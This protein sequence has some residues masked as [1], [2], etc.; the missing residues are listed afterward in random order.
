[1]TSIT[2]DTILNA[3]NVDR[4]ITWIAG[5]ARLTNLSGRLL[6]AH[7]AHAGLI[8]FWA[9][10]IALFELFRYDPTISMGQ[11]GL[12]LLP[13][14]A[15]LGIGVGAGGVITDPE[16]IFNVAVVHLISSAVLG[17]GGIFHSLR[18]PAVLNENDKFTGFFGYRWDDGNK[19]TTIIGIHLILLGAGAWLLVLKAMF[20]GG[21]FDPA[22]AG[23]GDLRVITSPSIRP[24][25]IFGYLVGQHG[26]GGMTAVDSLEDIVGG[27]IWV[28][29]LCILGGMWHCASQ[30]LSWA[31]KALVW[32]GEAYLSY[33]LAALAYMGAIASYFVWQNGLVYPEMFYGPLQTLRY[34]DGTVSARG[35]LCAFHV[36]FSVM[37]LLGHIWHAIQARGV[38]AGYNFRFA[39]ETGVRPVTLQNSAFEGVLA[40]PVNS[41]DYNRVFFAKLPIFRSGLSPLRRGLEV[42]MAH[43]YWLLGPFLKLGPMRDT[44]N[45]GVAGLGSAVGLVVIGSILLRIYGTAAYSSSRVEPTVTTVTLDT[46]R[47]PEDMRSKLGWHQFALGFL[48]GGAGSAFFAYIL[49]HPITL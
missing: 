26:L 31:K 34:A 14:L 5:N 47:L 44:P 18:G 25:Q 23:G 29:S 38:M 19:M 45:A 37:F 9:G 11:Q 30:P 17:A 3:T 16:T 20:F 27:H 22:I 43:G 42:G 40:T 33:S 46:M 39:P 48:I 15:T 1:M 7:V 35:W 13:H 41:L 4:R 21:L 32:S 12:I 28:G 8:V 10:A 6:G 24:G 2:T 49:L 36:A